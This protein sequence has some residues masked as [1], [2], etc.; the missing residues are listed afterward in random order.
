MKNGF[1]YRGEFNGHIKFKK[2]KWEY[3]VDFYNCDINEME[4][5]WLQNSGK[6][7]LCLNR[8]LKKRVNLATQVFSHSVA[9]R[10]S[11]L[12]QA[13]Q[14]PAAGKYTVQF[15]ERSILTHSKIAL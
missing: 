5:E 8:S 1:K 14:M 9:A 11:T 12:V 13:K 2:I 3:I 7:T 6:S 10:I 15:L 4:S